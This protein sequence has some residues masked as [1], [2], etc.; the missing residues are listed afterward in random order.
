[1][2]EV[3][4]MVA[5]LQLVNKFFTVHV[6]QRFINILYI[7][8]MFGK[9]ISLELAQDQ[10]TARNSVTYRNFETYNDAN[11]NVLCVN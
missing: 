4:E 8:E 3:L 1:V 9:P 11:I 5:D 6:T 2:G 7:D 10:N